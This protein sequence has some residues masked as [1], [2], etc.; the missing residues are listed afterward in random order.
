MVSVMKNS[1]IK[2]YIKAHIKM[3]NHKELVN[4]PGKMDKNIKDNGRMD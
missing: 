2:P 1:Q 3:V 4:I